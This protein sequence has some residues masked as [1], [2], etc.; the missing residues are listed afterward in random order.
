MKLTPHEKKILALIEKNPEI[1]TDTKKRIVIAKENGLSEK[2]LRNRIGDLKKYGV[3][4]LD[5]NT[6]FKVTQKS[7]SED[8]NNQ[9]NIFDTFSV[10]TQ[11]SYLDLTY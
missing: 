10:L 9:E 11:V 6:S 1:I 3:I 5:N 7:P 2:T 8:V 4:N